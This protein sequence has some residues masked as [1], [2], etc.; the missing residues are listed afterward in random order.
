MG[1]ACGGTLN[2]WYKQKQ[3]HINW[4]LCNSFFFFKLLILGRLWAVQNKLSA[5]SEY[6]KLN[7]HTDLAI[8]INTHS[9]IPDYVIAFRVLLGLT[10]RACDVC[11]SVC[12]RSGLS[13]CV[14]DSTKHACEQI[15]NLR[16]DLTQEGGETGVA[17]LRLG[18][19]IVTCV[20]I[21][22]TEIWVYLLNFSQE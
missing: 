18:E 2:D 20:S 22:Q 3:G 16:A 8:N 10:K 21:S 14:L 1:L 19:E 6:S 4:G 7:T 15:Q 11:F 13:S 5:I 17:V 12:D 9:K